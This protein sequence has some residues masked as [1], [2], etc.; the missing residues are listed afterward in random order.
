V[1]ADISEKEAISEAK[2]FEKVAEYLK[3]KEIK[4]AIYVPGRLVS[5]VV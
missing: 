4:K 1:A 2:N 3:D 5:L